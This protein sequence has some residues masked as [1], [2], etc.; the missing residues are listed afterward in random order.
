MI[1]HIKHAGTRQAAERVLCEMRQGSRL[2][3][4]HGKERSFALIEG[5][6][7]SPKV[8]TCLLWGGVIK[9]NQ[10]GL[11]DWDSQSFRIA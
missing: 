8:M 5:R 10:D 4:H 9:P 2:L 3:W 11:F 1:D 6:E 7:V